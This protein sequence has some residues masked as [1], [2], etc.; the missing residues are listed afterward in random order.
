MQ[1]KIKS[2]GVPKGN[3]TDALVIGLTDGSTIRMSKIERD[4]D[5][6]D[7]KIQTRMRALLG[8]DDFH[9]ALHPDGR[10]FYGLGKHTHWPWERDAGRG[11]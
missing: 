3:T 6:T 10:R 5:G 8:R 11:R 2:F 9:T 4:A 1:M 7:E